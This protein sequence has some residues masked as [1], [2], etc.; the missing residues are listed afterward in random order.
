MTLL[1]P[2][3]AL[4]GCRIFY[5]KIGI[6]EGHNALREGGRCPRIAEFSFELCSPKTS[7]VLGRLLGLSALGCRSKHPADLQVP[8]EK[9][10]GTFLSVI[11]LRSV[12]GAGLEP[13]SP[14]KGKKF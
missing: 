7:R 6:T 13:A 8:H 4:D 10:A 12:P 1:H 14:K 9:C 2:K 3:L 11:S 5:R